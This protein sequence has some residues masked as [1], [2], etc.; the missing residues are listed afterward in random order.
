MASAATS[1]FS[2]RSVV[3]TTF[4]FDGRALLSSFFCTGAN[5]FFIV[6]NPS[7]REPRQCSM[8]ST[9]MK[10]QSLPVVAVVPPSDSHSNECNLFLCSSDECDDSLGFDDGVD[11]E[12]AFQKSSV[13]ASSSVIHFRDDTEMALC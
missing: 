1:G 6:D 9:W 8:E 2:S 7:R 5:Q 13:L 3:L 10:Q 4:L 12:K 11:I